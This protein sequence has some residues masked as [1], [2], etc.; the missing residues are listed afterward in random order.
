MVTQRD[1]DEVRLTEA[2]DRL[3]AHIDL[4]ETACEG[5]TDRSEAGSV[6]RFRSLLPF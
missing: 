1:G 6:G 5:S 4:E 2:A 3:E